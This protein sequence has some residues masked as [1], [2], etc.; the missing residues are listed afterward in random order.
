MVQ[1][2]ITTLDETCLADS[3]VQELVDIYEC[4]NYLCLKPAAFTKL[5][6]C[7]FEKIQRYYDANNDVGAPAC[8]ILATLKHHRNLKSLLTQPQDEIFFKHL[9]IFIAIWL[10][11]V[12]QLQAVLKRFYNFEE[13]R[14]ASLSMTGGYLNKSQIVMNDVNGFCDI[15]PPFRDADDERKYYIKVRLTAIRCDES[16]VFKF[17]RK[18]QDGM[19]SMYEYRFYERYKKFNVNM[20]RFLNQDM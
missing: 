7:L 16:N 11:P 1:Q 14:F 19:I 2:Y 3:S 8:D 4:M 10:V 12:L 20:K 9:D 13:N 18:Y 6:K 17:M 5:F 15:L